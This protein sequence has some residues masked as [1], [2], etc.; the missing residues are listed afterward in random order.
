MPSWPSSIADPSQ[1]AKRSNICSL[2]RSRPRSS[3]SKSTAYRPKARGA[4]R[5]RQSESLTGGLRMPSARAGNHDEL[6]T[7]ATG[8]S[9]ADPRNP[10]GVLERFF[11]TEWG[12]LST[13]G[14]AAYENAARTFAIDSVCTALLEQ[15]NALVSG[16]G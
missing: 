1:W 14:E 12:Q 4:V 11:E 6:L 8:F 5:L 7:A 13:M 16:R 3:V 15:L 10:G 9:I 2:H